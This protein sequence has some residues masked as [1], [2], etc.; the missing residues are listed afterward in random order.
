[1]FRPG[2]FLGDDGKRERAHLTAFLDSDR[3]FLF[4]GDRKLCSL[5]SLEE[6]EFSFSCEPDGASEKGE[7]VNESLDGVLLVG[8]TSVDMLLAGDS[9]LGLVCVLS[10]GDV[11]V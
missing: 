11:L 4:P 3:K 8:E 9:V 7:V 6:T 5:S 1:M 2:I 10:W